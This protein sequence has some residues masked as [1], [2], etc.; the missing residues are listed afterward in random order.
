MSSQP[1]WH[2]YFQVAITQHKDSKYRGSSPN[3]HS[4]DE[5]GVG[6]AVIQTLT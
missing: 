2:I 1:H 4:P 6:N 3:G 5:G